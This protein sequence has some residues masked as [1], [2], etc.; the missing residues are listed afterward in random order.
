M[1]V[2]PIADAYAEPITASASLN[3]AS[4]SLVR[5]FC[6][7]LAKLQRTHTHTRA[8]THTNTHMHAHTST[9]K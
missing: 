3:M 9:V 1:T 4:S 7:K 2:V 5:G 6:G 8:H